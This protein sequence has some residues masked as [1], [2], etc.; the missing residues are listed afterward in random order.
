[1]EEVAKKREL[2]ALKE[3]N[4][5][6][7]EQCNNEELPQELKEKLERRIE[8]NKCEMKKCYNERRAANMEYNEEMSRRREESDGTGK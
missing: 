1:M 8:D 4:E 6:L 3:E 7:R 2:Q 5:Y